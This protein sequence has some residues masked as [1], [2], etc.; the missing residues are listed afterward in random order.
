[1]TTALDTAR[2]LR[3]RVDTLT[4]MGTLPEVMMRI[5]ELARDPKSSALDLAAAI[6]QEPALSLKVLRTVNSAYYG[7]QRRIM[8]VPDAVVVLGFDEVERLALTITIIDSVKLDE[9][10]F[11][12]L[13]ALWRHSLACSI[14]C[15][16][17]ELR[18]VSRMTELRGVHVAGL[19]H[20]I[21]KVILG[22]HFPDLYTRIVHA[23]KDTGQDSLEAER[24]MLGG[25][26]HCDIGSWLA[27]RWNL[28]E[29]LVAAIR[30]HHAP[31]VE[32][33]T[34]PLVHATHVADCITN[35]LGYSAQP[36][37]AHTQVSP[38]SAKIIPP[39]DHLTGAIREQLLRRQPLLSA[40]SSGSMF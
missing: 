19:L 22:S 2:S 27:E 17:C 31:A 29:A 4:E 16:V 24:T 9:N 21:G 34:H 28:P 39:D 6:N 38:V 12:A 5:M 20:D 32:E 8:T 23:V 25:I 14:A 40:V 18:F 13:R 35:S 26:T 30:D 7:L 10:G 3:Q 1:M 33:Q 15:T 11:K 37:G 36:A